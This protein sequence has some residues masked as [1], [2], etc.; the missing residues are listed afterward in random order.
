MREGA[1]DGVRE[2]GRKKESVPCNETELSV[3]YYKTITN[4]TVL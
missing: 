2:L 4:F 1:S 3:I